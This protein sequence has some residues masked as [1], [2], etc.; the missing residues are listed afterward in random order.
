MSKLVVLDAGH[1][2]HDSGAVGVNGLKESNKVLEI[3]KMVKSKLEAVGV[4]VVMTRSNDTFVSLGGRC[5]IEKSHSANC[6]VSIHCNSFSPQSHGHEVYC[7]PKSANSNRLA[8]LVYNEVIAAGLY[9]AKRGVKDGSKL[10]VVHGTSSP[11]V[12]VE[13]AFIDN[14][15]D[16]KLLVEHSDGFATAIAAGICKYLG[17]SPV[18]TPAPAP[19]TGSRTPDGCLI[20]GFTGKAIV[21]ANGGLNVRDKR[22]QD[23]DIIG[24]LPNNTP[25]QLLYTLNGWASV[26]YGKGVGYIYTKYLN[27]L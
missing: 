1:G 14:L 21:K 2:G 24:I 26:D 8:N 27:I 20:N 19:A 17:V 25:V 5:A 10:A 9:T 11:A 4:A 6:F 13:T 16:Y 12:L 18:K 22:G 3:A 23:G 7:Y 15:G